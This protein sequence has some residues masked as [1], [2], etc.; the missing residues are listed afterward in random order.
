MTVVSFP[1]RRTP[2]HL[3]ELLKDGRW[4]DLFL[5]VENGANMDSVVHGFPLGAALLK[6]WLHHHPAHLGRVHPLPPEYARTWLEKVPH[7]LGGRASVAWAACFG[8][9]QLAMDLLKRDYPIDTPDWGIW[10]AVMAGYIERCGTKDQTV[11]RPNGSEMTIPV[12]YQDKMDANE[13]WLMRQFMSLVKR[14]NK[15]DDPKKW[16]AESSLV[17]SVMFH[18][19]QV[20]QAFL[21]QGANPQ[22]VVFMTPNEEDEDPSSVAISLGHVAIEADNAKALRLLLE[23]GLRDSPIVSSDYT[24]VDTAV[25]CDRPVCLELLA[26]LLPSQDFASSLPN[27]MIHAVSVNNIPMVELL[28]NLGASLNTITP[29]GY[30]LM[31]QVALTG[32]SDMAHWLLSKGL[33]WEHEANNGVRPLELMKEHNPALFKQFQAPISAKITDLRFRKK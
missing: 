17:S 25:L 10:E 18:Q 6:A 9:W 7:E 22:H 3:H 20:F 33:S 27:A 23:R 24:L 5:A 13:V 30:T 28:L 4:E 15:L 2:L 26:D 1:A 19:N 11:V 29:S 8:Q 14:K 21:D 32:T 16:G 31:H 12:L